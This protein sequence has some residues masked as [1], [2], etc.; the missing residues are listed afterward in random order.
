[1]LQSRVV[2]ASLAVVALALAYVVEAELI[3]SL[4]SYVWAG[5]GGTFSVVVLLTLLWPKY[6]GKAV[7]LT[8]LSG[9]LFTIIWISTGMEQYITARLLTFFVALTVAV[10]STYALPKK[11]V[12]QPQA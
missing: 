4:V 12:S 1:L 7:V 2:T 5:I 8:I 10:I 3:F 11:L 9:L 6:H